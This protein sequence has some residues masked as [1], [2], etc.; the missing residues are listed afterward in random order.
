MSSRWMAS[1]VISS[2]RGQWM[3]SGRT[4]RRRTAMTTLAATDMPRNS[5]CRLRSSG[6]RPIPWRMACCG[7]RIWTGWPSSRI[8]P[9]VAGCA[10]KIV[11]ASSVRPAPTSPA[12]P[13]ISPL[14]SVKLT[15]CTWS[16][17]LRLR[18]SS[19]ISLPGGWLRRSYIWPTSRPTIMRM[20]SSV[21]TS[22]TGCVPTSMPSRRTVTRSQMART[23]SSRCEMKTIDTPR[24]R[25]SRMRLNS[26]STSRS[27]S[28]EVGSSITIRRASIDRALATSIIC[29]WAIEKK[30][31][32]VRT[33]SLRSSSA[34]SASACWYSLRQWTVPGTAPCG[35]RP[36]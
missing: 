27:V 20:M 18:T 32:G 34:R 5:P 7:R 6:T 14:C 1:R 4:R 23:S 12:T 19:T 28:E 2:T 30:R 31:T 9:P 15:S 36:R 22:A 8:S 10:P 17:R 26:V 33:F 29:C 11:S 25:R 24:A 3:T 13:R 35:S 16:P 21:V